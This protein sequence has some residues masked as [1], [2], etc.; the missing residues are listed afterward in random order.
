MNLKKY[1]FTHRGKSSEIASYC[2]VTSQAVRTWGKT[3]V[4][5]K[6]VLEVWSATEGAVKLHEMRPDLYPINLIDPRIPND[7][8][9]RNAAPAAAALAREPD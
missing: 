5:A 8:Q 9:E 7:R 6:R 3:Q 4:P 2:G 1:L